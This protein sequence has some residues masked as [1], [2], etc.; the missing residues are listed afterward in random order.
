M[1][2]TTPP[3]LVHDTKPW[4]GIRGPTNPRGSRL[5]PSQ[6]SSSIQA[7][8]LQHQAKQVSILFSKATP[9]VHSLSSTHCSVLQMLREPHLSS[10]TAGASTRLARVVERNSVP[11]DMKAQSCGK[12][13][14]YI[15]A[16]TQ[17][18]PRSLGR[19]EKVRIRSESRLPC[20]IR[21][22]EFLSC[23]GDSALTR[24]HGVG[25]ACPD[26]GSLGSALW[27]HPADSYNSEH[28]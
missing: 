5:A 21:P 11:G 10:G 17:A 14:V 15:K 16:G 26:C 13:C 22:S 23:P 3:Q 2:S 24:G 9:I 8:C 27:E 25:H 28:G 7:Q 12:A 19:G 4:V 1:S 6:K 20:R 18:L